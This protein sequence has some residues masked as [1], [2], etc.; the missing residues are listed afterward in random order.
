GNTA[1]VDGGR[2]DAGLDPVDASI[3]D[4]PNAADAA[5]GV[6]FASRHCVECTSSEDCPTSN[7]PYCVEHTCQACDPADHAGCS[8]DGLPICAPVD[9]GSG[10]A[11]ELALAQQW[12][13]VQCS[14]DDDCKDGRCLNQ[15][16]VQC[17][18]SNDCNSR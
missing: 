7:S 13:C 10:A 15:S 14:V 2:P 16:C 11:P 4:A 12:Q 9:R 8:D 5:A 18:D 6:P 3:P 1:P 17:V